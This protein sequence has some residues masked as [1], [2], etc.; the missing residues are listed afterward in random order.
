MK[1]K[2]ITF[3]FLIT[4]TASIKLNADQYTLFKPTAAKSKENTNPTPLE[5]GQNQ[6]NYPYP[7]FNGPPGWPSVPASA[8]WVMGYPYTPYSDC[9]QSRGQILC[10]LGNGIMPYGSGYSMGEW[11]KIPV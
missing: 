1:F 9:I 2:T 11:Q 4:V 3:L 8:D 10:G 5:S 7:N 6:N